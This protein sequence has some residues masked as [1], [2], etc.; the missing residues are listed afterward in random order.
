MASPKNYSQLPDGNA[1]INKDFVLPIFQNGQTRQILASNAYFGKT[2]VAVYSDADLPAVADG[3]ITLEPTTSYIFMEQFIIPFPILLPAGYVGVVKSA[4]VQPLGMGSSINTGGVS[5]FE[6]LNIDGTAAI[7]DNGTGEIHIETGGT[8]N[9]LDGQFVNIFGTPEALYNLQRLQI[10]NVTTEGFDVLSVSFINPESGAFDT[11]C[12]T[13]FL[14]DIDMFSATGIGN[15]INVTAA[16][17]PTSLIL[18]RDITANGFSEMGIIRPVSLGISSALMSFS[19]NGLE[20]IDGQNVS[21]F[22]IGLVDIGN[23]TDT[24]GIILDGANTLKIII[25]TVEFLAT[26]T[27]QHAIRIDP[28]ITSG[29]ISI[30]NSPDNDV[31]TDYFSLGAGGLDQTNPQVKT[32]DNGTRED[33]MSSAQVGFTDVADPIVV[34]I[35]TEAVPV[36]IGGIQFISDDLER[37]TATTGGQITNLTKKTQKYQITFSGLIEKAG[38]GS[39]DIGLLL[40]KNGSLVLTD[41]FDIPHSVNAGIIQI[42]ATRTFELAENDTI[43]IAVVNFDGTSAIN[44]TQANISYS[45]ES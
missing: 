20:I 7:T 4:F 24:N 37:A 21:L 28:V 41:T 9:L 42:S 15:W 27:S 40:I 19:S 25:N 12:E 1:L 32:K 22:Q 5:M 36:L 31:I 11:G 13:F 45:R 35:V 38:G 17:S 39:T 2:V 43:D 18:I 16:N 34:T 44:V 33:S 30:K 14:T 23:A 6:T 8:H 10:S 3:V 29:V 26:D